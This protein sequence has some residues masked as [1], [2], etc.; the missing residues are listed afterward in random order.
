MTQAHR[1]RYGKA[2]SMAID[3]AMAIMIA[4]E[5]EPQCGLGDRHEA[6]TPLLAFSVSAVCMPAT[7]S[8]E[9][10]SESAGQ[11]RARRCHSTMI[12]CAADQL[13]DAPVTRKIT[14]VAP[15]A[16]TCAVICAAPLFDR[17]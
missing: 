2:P 3:G 10:P 1:R 17:W 9:S 13:R 16:N 14:V 6:R 15:H 11:S 4:T 7:A 5:F 12:A 8:G